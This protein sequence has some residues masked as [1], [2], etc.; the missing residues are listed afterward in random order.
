MVVRKFNYLESIITK[1]DGC[2]EEIRRRLMMARSA[3]A[4]LTRIWKDTVITRALHS[5]WSPLFQDMPLK[6]VR[7]AE[8]KRIR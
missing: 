7:K 8:A 6:R 2:E 1:D 5:Y 3:T 4:K